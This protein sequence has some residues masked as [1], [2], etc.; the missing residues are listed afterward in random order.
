MMW[1]LESLMLQLWNVE[2]VVGHPVGHERTLGGIDN[3]L[4]LIDVHGFLCTFNLIS[5]T[6]AMPQEAQNDDV[7]SVASIIFR[8]ARR[9]TIFYQSSASQVI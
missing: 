2:M 4:M 3:G 6:S 9:M 1:S 8:D 5:S 7:A